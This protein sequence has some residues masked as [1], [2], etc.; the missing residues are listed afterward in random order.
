M[1]A[2]DDAG[3]VV[4]AAPAHGLVVEPPELG[5]VAVLPAVRHPALHQVEPVRD[6]A[7]PRRRPGPA[8][9][10][11]RL[12]RRLRLCLRRPVAAALLY[13][14]TMTHD[15]WDTSNLGCPVRRVYEK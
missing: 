11:P 5:Q 15:S 7:P 4:L 3:D 6:L 1:Q 2:H 9:A 12:A 13:E 8:R 14:M 10:S